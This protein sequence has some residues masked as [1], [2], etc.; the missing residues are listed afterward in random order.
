MTFTLAEMS[1]ALE[2]RKRIPVGFFVSTAIWNQLKES[3]RSGGAT[4]VG[5]KVVLDPSL[6]DTE[7]EVAF[8][9]D[10]WSKRLV[11]VSSPVRGSK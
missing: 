5:A 1:K 11:A 4:L 2:D 9:E 6:P 7:F 10:A 3:V 8:T